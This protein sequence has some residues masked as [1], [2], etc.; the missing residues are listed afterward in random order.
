MDQVFQVFIGASEPGEP[1]A[2]PFRFLAYQRDGSLEARVNVQDNLIIFNFLTYSR[3]KSLWI[4][5]S[6]WYEY[7]FHELS[8]ISSSSSDPLLVVG[9]AHQIIDVFRSADVTKQSLPREVIQGTSNRIAPALFDA[10]A[11]CQSVHGIQLAGSF[12]GRAGIMI[13]SLA[14]DFGAEEQIGWRVKINHTLEI[15]LNQP[16]TFSED[17]PTINEWIADGML[18]LHTYNKNVV[19]SIISPEMRNKI[20]IDASTE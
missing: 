7:F 19:S 20:N 15:H 9:C 6:R 17:T 12:G 5:A 2:V 14:V 11:P 18:Q 16:L 3:W 10:T 4:R 8:K 1:P 13:D